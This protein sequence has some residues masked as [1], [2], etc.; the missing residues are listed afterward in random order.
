[1]KKIILISFTILVCISC[2]QTT[3]ENCDT[4]LKANE[5]VEKNIKTYKT[6]WD[7]FFETIDSNA[8]Y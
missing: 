2:N 6:A 1:M 5:K 8:K 3:S 7:V 4:A